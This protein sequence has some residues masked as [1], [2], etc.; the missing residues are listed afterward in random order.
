MTDYDHW[1]ARFGPTNYSIIYL[2]NLWQHCLRDSRPAA[3]PMRNRG[4]LNRGWVVTNISSRLSP[5][6]TSSI[7]G[8]AWTWRTTT[9]HIYRVTTK[10]RYNVGLNCDLIL[11][12]GEFL[13]L[14]VYWGLTRCAPFDKY[15]SQG[16]G[17]FLIFATAP[18]A[19]GTDVWGGTNLC[20]FFPFLVGRHL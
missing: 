1:I 7:R 8:T 19:K 18:E 6:W 3:T 13:S 17:W 20:V 5:M 4:S 14:L 10:E 12:P 11:R 9:M 2:N 16:F 15:A